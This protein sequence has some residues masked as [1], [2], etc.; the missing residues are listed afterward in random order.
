MNLADAAGG[1]LDPVCPETEVPTSC[2]NHNSE[3][4]NTCP[5]WMRILEKYRE[6]LETSQLAVQ[7]FTGQRNLLLFP[8]MLPCALVYPSGG[9][10]GAVH[11]PF[12]S[13]DSCGMFPGVSR[14]SRTRC[15]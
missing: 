3:T 4:R 6:E 2:A 10:L 1:V 13:F 9:F 14:R 8:R 7:L 5:A 11:G 12:L 15:T